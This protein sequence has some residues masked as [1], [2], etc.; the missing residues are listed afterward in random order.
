M[1]VYHLVQK[2]ILPL[3][4][5]EA[6]EFFSTPSNLDKITPEHM[7]FTTLYSSGRGPKMYPGQI[8]SYKMKI[9]PLVTVRWVTEITQVHHHDYFIDEQRFGPYAMWHHEH[10]FKKVEGGA[11]MIDEVTYA[12]PFGFIG[13][14]ANWLFV[15]KQL[16][17]IFVFRY[18]TLEK[19]FNKKAMLHTVA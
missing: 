5:D 14:F 11:E 6:W 12:I 9:L 2:Q 18:N 4:L 15:E 3:T 8:I 7:N 16:E 1:K 19:L 17:D 10:R 13:R